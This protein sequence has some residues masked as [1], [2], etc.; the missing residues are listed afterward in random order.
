MLSQS[1][2]II[3]TITA[4]NTLS[5]KECK[6][7][8]EKCLLNKNKLK[9][10]PIIQRDWFIKKHNLIPFYESIFYH[11][12]N[13]NIS[14]V[15]RLYRIYNSKYDM[16]VCKHCKIRPVT[17]HN[18]KEGFKTFCSFSCNAT[19]NKPSQKLS[20]EVKK[21]KSQKISQARIGLKFS[22]EWKNKLKKSAQST[23]VKKKKAN[24]N[25]AKYGV[26]NT[27]VLGAFSSTSAKKYIESLLQI[28]KIDINCI[29]YKNDDIGKKEF[30]Q[31]IDVPFLNKKRFFSYD[32]VIFN[33]LES[34]DNKDISKIN[35]V[36]EYNGPW[37]YRKEEIAG[38]ENEPATPYKS[39][40]FT[41][42]Q[43][44]ELDQLKMYHILLCGA[45]EVLIYW[46]KHSLMDRIFVD[47][48]G[49][50]IQETFQAE[51]FLNNLI[52]TSIMHL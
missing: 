17:F 32:L 41:K 48:R 36:F 23:E 15:E 37:H 7:V 35:L 31:M 47:Q 26:T 6:T 25:L 1:Q 30:W 5:Q 34:C 11:T 42:L 49:Q 38:K 24:T 28:W 33:D 44:Y 18:F 52:Q 27:G 13:L 8:I 22:E 10:L 16:Q 3:Q 39:N 50:I 51:V 19:Y 43:V 14:L 4:T 21:R 20:L 12:S 40:K 2:N 9:L 46:E 29:M 45:K